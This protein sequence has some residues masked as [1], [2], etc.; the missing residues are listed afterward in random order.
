MLSSSVKGR[1]GF[2]TNVTPLFLA[3]VFHFKMGSQ[4]A[5]LAVF[6]PAN[7]ALKPLGSVHVLNVSL[8]AF[9]IAETSGTNLTS[10]TKGRLSMLYPIVILESVE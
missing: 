7:V 8:Q 2:V 3:Q 10:V 6:P 4:M 9:S 1:E 5:L